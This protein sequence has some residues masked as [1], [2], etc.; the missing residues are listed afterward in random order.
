MK[1][2]FIAAS[3]FALSIGSALAGPAADAAQ[4]H[5]AAIGAG[6]IPIIMRGYADNAQLNWVGGPLDGTYVS[7]DT[8]RGTWEKF[9]KAVG[10]LKVTI[11]N[12][13]ESVNPKGATVLANVQF[14]GKM[15]IKVRYVLTYRDGK[16]VSETWQ[17]DPKLAIAAY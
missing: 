11:N 6:D 12:L 7:Q 10:P 17:I 8:I 15:P 5:F 16:L 3:L 4:T 9:G 14:E 1:Q 13:E 2:L